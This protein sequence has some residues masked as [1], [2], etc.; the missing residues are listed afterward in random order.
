MAEPGVDPYS[1]TDNVG[2]TKKQRIDSVETYLAKMASDINEIDRK[3][4]EA[5]DKIKSMQKDLDALN[6]F[7]KSIE[8]KKKEEE[9]ALKEANDPKNID[10]A[11][12]KDKTELE[13]LKDDILALKNK[14]IEKL[15]LE[16]EYLREDM[17]NYIIKDN[18]KKNY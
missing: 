10:K 18:Q 7:K 16:M 5:Q 14:D 9:D 15:K 11:K 3:F 12:S 4:S 13:K 17:K 2:L 1:S 6:D 8:A